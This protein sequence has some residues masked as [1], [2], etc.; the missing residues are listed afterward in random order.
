MAAAASDWA[1][2][3]RA[4]S[5][6]AR[7]RVMPAS[8]PSAPNSGPAWMPTDGCSGMEQKPSSV[9]SGA[10]RPAHTS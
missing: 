9:V 10:T 5:P 8:T 2:S 6:V 1:I 7:A 4:G 3:R